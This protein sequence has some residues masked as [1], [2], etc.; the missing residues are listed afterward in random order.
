MR[1]PA[2]DDTIVTRPQTV[3]PRSASTARWGGRTEFVEF[4]LE[5]REGDVRAPAST[6]AQRR[7]LAYRATDLHVMARRTGC[8]RSACRP[9]GSRMRP[10]ARRRCSP[11]SG[12]AIAA[13]RAGWWRPIRRDRC[14]NGA[15]GTGSTRPTRRRSRS[16]SRRS[17][18]RAG[19]TFGPGTRQ[20]CLGSAD[21]LD[22]LV[23][24]LTARAAQLGR[25]EPVPDAL[26][27]RR[28]VRAGS[29][30]R[31]QPS[32]RF[33]IKPRV[34]EVCPARVLVPLFAELLEQ[35]ELHATRARPAAH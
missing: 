25:T 14:G 10:S 7:A 24:A 32:R 16:C 11:G 8:V 6:I 34:P 15:C 23:V 33:V 17:S 12:N 27:E 31:T 29:P 2:D 22:A 21:A 18:E 13:A 9:T 35:R 30:C 19:L 20:A 28:A 1:C 3:R 4:V 26:R 5:H